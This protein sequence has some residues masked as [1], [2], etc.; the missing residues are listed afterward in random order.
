MPRS[1]LRRIFI[2]NASHPGVRQRLAGAIGQL[3]ADPDAHLGE[4]I[5]PSGERVFRVTIYDLP[6]G[7]LYF[8]FGVMRLDDARILDIRG[9]RMTTRPDWA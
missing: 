3:C 2:W 4:V 6:G 1:L 5:P 8:V 7:P 9:G